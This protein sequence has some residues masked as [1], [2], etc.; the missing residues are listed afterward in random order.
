MKHFQREISIIFRRGHSP[1]PCEVGAGGTPLLPIP[2]RRLALDR[3]L[4]QFDFPTPFMKSYIR[5][6]VSIARYGQSGFGGGLH[7]LSAVVHDATR[8]MQPEC[9]QRLIY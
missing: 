9:E 2:P 7:C 1:F 5:L 3:C 8:A 6:C 4:W